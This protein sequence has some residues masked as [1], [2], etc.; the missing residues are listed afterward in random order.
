MLGSVTV[1]STV[2]AVPGGAVAVSELAEPTTTL[3]AALLANLTVSAAANPVPV[4]VTVFPPA[5]DPLLGLTPV[6][7]AGQFWPRCWRT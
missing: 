3:L 7:G 5:V 1:T 2:P 4:I 6:T